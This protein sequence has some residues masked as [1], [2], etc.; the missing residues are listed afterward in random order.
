MRTP[1]P[2]AEKPRTRVYHPR[3]L[4]LRG[5]RPEDADLPI[6]WSS[7]YLTDEEDMGQA[8]EQG[9]IIKIMMSSL[10]RWAEERGWTHVLVGADQFFAWVRDE[11]LVRVSPDIYLLDDAPE[12]TLPDSWQ[13][14]LPAHRP[15]RFAIEVVSRDK[16]KDYEDAPL[17]YD[18]LGTSELVIFDPRAVL[19]P[20][21]PRRVP[22]QLYRR[23]AKGAFLRVYEGP[24]PTYSVELDAYLVTRREGD[25][26]RLRMARDTA[27]QDLVP[28]EA[29][30]GRA[31]A[32]ARRK[33]EEAQRQAEER[34]AKEATARCQAEEAR[35]QAEERASA[36]ADRI[37]KLEAML[38]DQARKEPRS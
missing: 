24:G 3:D 33:A 7:W 12:R 34:A 27:G 4:A 25:K 35:R 1:E 16:K 5:L 30:H 31:E 11:P 2:S 29:E 6:D 19:R 32:Q 15:P 20:M 37:G 10:D 38:R 21:S 36:A 14:W 8:G 17:K 13:T 23:D 22:L 26:A 18:L 9:R 28:T